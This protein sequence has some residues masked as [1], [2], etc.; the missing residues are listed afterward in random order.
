MSEFVVSRLHDMLELDK[1]HAWGMRGD[2][3]AGTE[4]GEISVMG[5]TPEQLREAVAC[6]ERAA[7]IL[8]D[9]GDP[10]GVAFYK[11]KATMTQALH[12]RTEDPSFQQI[13]DV[14]SSI[15]DQPLTLSGL[16]Q[17]LNGA[18]EPEAAEA[19]EG[20]Q[21]SSAASQRDGAGMKP[22]AAQTASKQPDTSRMTSKGPEKKK[23]KKSQKKKKKKR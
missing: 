22:E 12:K 14:W 16:M 6:F 3:L 19:S 11:H 7:K 5:R 4:L 13:S 10:Q 21:A 18:A 2:V 17:V 8:Q 23:K 20:T 1:I 9:I 15:S